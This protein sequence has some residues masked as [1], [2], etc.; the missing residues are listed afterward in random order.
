[1]YLGIPKRRLPNAQIRRNIILERQSRPSGKRLSS[2]ELYFFCL[3]KQKGVIR[4]KEDGP[5]YNHPANVLMSVIVNIIIFEF[6][7]FRQ[8]NIP[9]S[10]RKSLKLILQHKS[11]IIFLHAEFIKVLRSR[12]RSS[13]LNG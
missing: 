6:N 4:G 11:S 9:D 13:F 5:Y 7:P 12:L 10:E 2:L 8:T 3:K 1:M